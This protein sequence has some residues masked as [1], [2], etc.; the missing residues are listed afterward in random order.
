MGWATLGMYTGVYTAHLGSVLTCFCLVPMRRCL[1]W[2][3]LCPWGCEKECGCVKMTIVVRY[4]AHSLLLVFVLLYGEIRLRLG[5][6]QVFCHKTITS[7]GGPSS[8]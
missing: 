5:Q 7:K 6:Y 2:C 8:L 4:R 1:F 3:L